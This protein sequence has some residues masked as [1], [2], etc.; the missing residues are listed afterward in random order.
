MLIDIGT[1]ELSPEYA[2]PEQ[3]TVKVRLSN[4]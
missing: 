1:L 3:R 4:K 2:N